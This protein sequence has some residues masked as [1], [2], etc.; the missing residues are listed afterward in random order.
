M[1]FSLL[2]FAIFTIG[3]CTCIQCSAAEFAS[4]RKAPDDL[5]G[6]LTNDA[7]LDSE[8]ETTVR[9]QLAAASVSSVVSK[10]GRYDKILLIYHSHHRIYP[11][12]LSFTI[13][14]YNIFSLALEPPC[15]H[16]VRRQH[17]P[18]RQWLPS[19]GLRWRWQTCTICQVQ[20]SCWSR[21]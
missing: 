18:R 3:I 12:S 2:S 15:H 16:Y 10:P 14:L 17:L 9:R 8:E 19:W 20:W 7:A 13:H 11:F 6:I 4:L 1:R 5:A 21:C